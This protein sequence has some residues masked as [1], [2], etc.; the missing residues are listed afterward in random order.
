MPF[1]DPNL[2][3]ELNP[4]TL[5]I[6]KAHIS[7]SDDTDEVMRK[8]LEVY[9]DFSLADDALEYLEKISEDKK[10]A[11][12][13]ETRIKLNELFER[14]IVAGKNISLEAREF[15]EAGHRSRSA[16][17]DLYRDITGNPRTP[18]KLFEELS[19]QF[20]FEKLNKVIKFLL[21]ALGRDLKAKG[22]SIPKALLYTLLTETRNLQAILAVYLFFKGR[23][24]IVYR[25]FDKNDLYFPK[26]LSFEQMARLFMGLLED[27]YPS[28]VKV[29]KMAKPMGIE[30][31]IVAQIIIFTH[32][33]DA[34]RN[35][36]PKLYRNQ[37]HMHE[38]LGA[39]MDALEELDDA[40][41]AEYEGEDEEEKS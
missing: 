15:S 7:D 27:R 4:K 22:S 10:L 24:N 41:H 33:R 17:R 12:I 6:L 39:Y 20:D 9:P 1:Q 36:A 18:N 28:P 30:D 31:E 26:Q 37:Q 3:P 19:T 25:G 23:M 35:V 14:E 13:K 2:N 8:L 5:L 29:I 32:F 11:Q 38:L 21:N 34:V 40:L 16:L